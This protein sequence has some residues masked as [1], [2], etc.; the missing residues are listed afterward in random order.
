MNEAG[1]AVLRSTVMTVR[2][3][4]HR[5]GTDEQGRHNIF[6]YLLRATGTSNAQLS[7]WTN[8]RLVPDNAGLA[9]L[10]EQYA[11]TEAEAMLLAAANDAGRRGLLTATKNWKPVPSSP[12]DGSWDTQLPS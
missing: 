10:T 6:W 12:T 3:F 7:R 2:H 4:S 8:D 1:L 5:S 11:I 9:R